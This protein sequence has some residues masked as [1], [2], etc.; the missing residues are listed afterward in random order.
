MFTGFPLLFAIVVLLFGP[1][2]LFS[3]LN[4][5]AAVN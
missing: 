5:L 2:V 4:P 1:L 3:N